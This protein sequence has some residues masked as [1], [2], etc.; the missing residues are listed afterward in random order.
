METNKWVIEQ[1]QVGTR[2][3]KFLLEQMPDVSRTRIQQ[4]IIIT[5][6]K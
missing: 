4:W 2:L 5:Q 6:P 3:D 1:E